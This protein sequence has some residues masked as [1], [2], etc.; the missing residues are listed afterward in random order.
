MRRQAKGSTLLER[1]K[2]RAQKITLIP[3]KTALLAGLLA[4]T[5]SV[6]SVLGHEETQPVSATAEDVEQ[7]LY[8]RLMTSEIMIKFMAS[9]PAMAKIGEKRQANTLGV[10]FADFRSG[11]FPQPVLNRNKR[12][13]ILKRDDPETVSFFYW[14]TLTG[15]GYRPKGYKNLK[16]L[17]SGLLRFYLTI[18]GQPANSTLTRPH[19][20]KGIGCA[21]VPWSQTVTAQDFLSQALTIP[22][23]FVVSYSSEMDNALASLV[24]RHELMHCNVS[25]HTDMQMWFLSGNLG[26]LYDEGLAD[27]AMLFNTVIDGTYDKMALPLMYHLRI[28]RE[29]NISTDP[30]TAGSVISPSDFYLNTQMMRHLVGSGQM[31]EGN[32]LLHSL[33]KYQ[34]ELEKIANYVEEYENSMP[35]NR[36][37][38]KVIRLANSFQF[39]L[40]NPT[41][42]SPELRIHAAEFL[43]ALK[44]V[45]PRYAEQM[46]EPERVNPRH[47]VS[48]EYLRL[49]AYSEGRL[50]KLPNW[51]ADVRPYRE[52]KEYDLSKLRF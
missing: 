48:P 51:S 2:K 26:R 7:N 38:P 22:K 23:E 3:T 39:A 52:R 15:D 16:N 36:Q 5:L 8:V 41:V 47:Y 27:E 12:V 37:N 42:L 17:N 10:P 29:L 46:T 45:A 20:D 1:F 50:K 21:V 9:S 33:Q 40:N 35:E 11:V 28:L 25:R 49:V 44:E 19:V 13:R 6:G 34:K 31:R 32:A 18:Y 4:T 24:M 43:I 14:T 30:E